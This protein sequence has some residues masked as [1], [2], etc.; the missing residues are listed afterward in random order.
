MGRLI[1]VSHQIVAGM[2]TYP[3]LP[4]PVIEEHLSFD[5]SHGTYAPGTE[6]TIGRI[7]MV[8]N[9]GTYLDTPAHRYRDGSDLADLP[10]EKVAALPGVVVDVAGREAGPE[11]FEG[12]DVAGRAVLIRTG[13]D[14]HWRTGAY[15]GPGHPFL[16][17]EGARL[18]VGAGAALVGIDSVNIDD[19]SSYSAG[20]RPAHSLLL[21][22]GIP[23]VEHLCLLGELPAEGFEFFAVP[24]KVRGMATLPVR[25]FAI[26][27]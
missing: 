3:G 20:A 1:D 4:A 5:E 13:W 27:P 8:G 7:S 2:T 9:T 12:V 19:T 22:A 18:L 6:F 11:A 14:R 15:G 17:E 24:A 26:V 10:L 16:T 21:A 23:V 25:A